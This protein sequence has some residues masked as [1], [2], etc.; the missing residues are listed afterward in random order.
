M[1]DAPDLSAT[2][3]W[4]YA[5]ITQPLGAGVAPRRTDEMVT[6]SPTLTSEQRLGIYRRSYYARLLECMESMF[7]ALR[8][9]I[10]VDLFRRFSLGYLQANAPES[11]T[12]NRLADG[13]PAYLGAT[14]PEAGP[15]GERETWPDF[16]IELA[17]LEFAFLQTFDGPGVEGQWIAGV[18]QILAIPAGRLVATLVPCLRLFSFQYPVH[19]YLISCK[20][21]QAP[22]LPDPKASFV[23]MTRREYRIRMLDLSLPQYKVLQ[24]LDGCTSLSS[25]AKDFR[26]VGETVL[27]DWLAEWALQGLIFTVT[28]ASRAAT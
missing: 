7:P 27:T 3:S 23:A 15:S 5:A 13:F 26:E 6:P 22:E 25:L 17:T 10:G 19:T 11:Y 14:R 8:H 2:Q 12:L 4:M 20:R 16:L 21:G 1:S 9:A 18:S 28:E 24:R